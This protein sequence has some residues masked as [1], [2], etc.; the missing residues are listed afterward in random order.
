MASRRGCA[1]RRCRGRS[2]GSCARPASQGQLQGRSIAAGTHDRDGAATKWPAASPGL[3]ASGLPFSS[4]LLRWNGL[5]SAW[6]RLQ[7]RRSKKTSHPGS[8]ARRAR[9]GGSAKSPGERAPAH[10]PPAAPVPRQSATTD[11]SP[12]LH[13]LDQSLRHIAIAIRAQ[14]HQQHIVKRTHVLPPAA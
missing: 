9:P 3:R 14:R 2:A 7:A 10:C 11:R 12:R 5:C 4:G 1:A 13:R 6:I 8:R